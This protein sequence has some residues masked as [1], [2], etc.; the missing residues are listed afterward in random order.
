MPSV[1]GP[2]P[3]TTTGEGASH[4]ALPSAWHAG[5]RPGSRTRSPRPCAY[6]WQLRA[7]SFVCSG[8]HTWTRFCNPQPTHQ[9][10]LRALLL[11]SVLRTSAGGWS[12][13]QS[14]HHLE[15]ATKAPSVPGPHFLGAHPGPP[16]TAAVTPNSHPRPEEKPRQG[17]RAALA[18][19]RW[20]WPTQGE[21]VK[22][23]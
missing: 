5:T 6:G 3:S 17:G 19:L 2:P 21:V 12:A 14:H 22:G 8:P 9:H 13:P 10:T 15:A 1:P 23:P 16:G 11:R 4:D 18:Q 20:L 7:G